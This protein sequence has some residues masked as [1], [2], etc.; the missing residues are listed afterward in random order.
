MFLLPKCKFTIQLGFGLLLSHITTNVSTLISAF[1]VKSLDGDSSWQKLT[2]C[3]ALKACHLETITSNTC[4]TKKTD[5]SQRS[6]YICIFRFVHKRVFTR[7]SL[8]PTPQAELIKHI[9]L[10]IFEKHLETS[11]QNR[12]GAGIMLHS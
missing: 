5:V 7:L 3:Y 2:S 12:N 9:V 1:M 11:Y 10:S 8:L 4:A 6:I